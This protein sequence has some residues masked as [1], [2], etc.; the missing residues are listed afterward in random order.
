MLLEKDIER[1]CGRAAKA[2]GCLWYKW[3]SPS[4]RGVPDRILIRPNGTVAFVELKRPGKHPTKLQ[5]HCIRKLR[6]QG[7]E[8]HV[9]NNVESFKDILDA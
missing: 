6:D 9:I 4:Q 2:R 8:V 3:V 5:A 7:C 1:Q